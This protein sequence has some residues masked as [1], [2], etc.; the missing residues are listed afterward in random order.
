MGLCT[1]VSSIPGEYPGFGLADKVYYINTVN[2]EEI[3]EAAQAEGID[4]ICTSGTDVAVATI[5]YVCE[6]MGLAGLS[7]RAARAATDKALMKEAFLRGGVAAADF[8]K[9]YSLEEARLAARRIGYPVVVKRVDSSGSRGI[10]LVSGEEQLAA[11]Y[12][13]AAGLSRKKYVLI[14]EMLHGTE[15]GVDG[16]VQDGK[17]VFLAPHEKLVYHSGTVTMPV[18]HGFP[19]RGSEAQKREIE[20]QVRR[21]VDALGLDNCSVNADVFVDGDR[22]WI[23]EMGGRTGATC[24]PELIS[25]YYGFDFYEKILQNALGVRLDLRPERPGVPCMAKLLM[26]PVDGVITAVDEEGLSRIRKGKVEV[27]LD[28]PRGH[29][30]E[31]MVNG[32]TRIGHVAAPAEDVGTLEEILRR[33]YGCIYVNGVSLE[34]L[35]KK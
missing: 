33:V 12:E 15:I 7:A 21:A 23:I 22:A 30:V 11:A 4:G 31:R 19:Y 29:F 27:V 2:Q 17:L 26:S 16:V 14:E 8:R 25:L 20:L 28:Y 18:G 3:L 6:K 35:W 32:T 5:G 24:I 9:V 10:M 13:N 1:I 34:E